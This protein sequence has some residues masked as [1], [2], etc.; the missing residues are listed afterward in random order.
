MPQP[1]DE[2]GTL[3]IES[4]TTAPAFKP[5]HVRRTK[6]IDD[7]RVTRSRMV[8][9]VAP[10][11]YGKTSLLAEWAER[12][13]RQTAWLTLKPGDD[14]P[15]EL[16]RMVARSCAGLDRGHSLA[17]E[18]IVASGGDALSRMAPAVGMA[19]SDT[20]QPF[21]LFID[22][23]HVLNDERSVDALGIALAGVPDGS[24][25]VLAGR[26]RT[27]A[28][29]RWR[30]AL[31]SAH[32]GI[33]QLRIDV[34][35]AAL[36][37]RE[38]GATT[39]ESVL[40]EWVS[41]CEGWAA[42]LHMCALLAEENPFAAVRDED[43]LADYLYQECMNGLPGEARDFLLRTSVLQT[44]IPDLCDAV[45]GRDDSA[46]ILRELEARQMFVTAD[47]AH[48]TYHLH[49]LF[50]EYLRN[51]L[52][53]DSPTAASA[54]HYKAAV[55]FQERGQLTEAIDHAIAANEFDLA[56]ALVTA[57][58]LGTYEAGQASR[59]GR[60]LDQIGDARVLANPAAVVV[61][62]W[63][64][65][66][67][68]SDKDAEKWSTLLGSLP[69]EAEA[70]GMNVASAKAM[71][72]A[73]SMKG[74]FDAALSDA[75][76]ACSIEGIDSPWRDPALQI[77]GSTLLHAGQTTRA[78]E[79]L[80]AA[81]HVADARNNAASLA[82]CE[83]DLS[84]LAIEAGEWTVAAERTATVL[85]AIQ[86]AGIEDYVMVPYA[87]SAAACAELADGR[88]S[89]GMGHLAWG[90]SE[91]QRCGSA[92]PLLG[93]PTR[94]LLARANLMVGDGNAVKVLLSEIDAM[95][96][97][98]EGRGVLDARIEFMREALQDFELRTG[99]RN[100][101][102]ALTAAEQR[103]LP[104]LQTHL[105]RAEIAQRLF[106]SPNTVGTQMSMIFR[107]FGAT[108]RAE[109][110][111]TAFELELLGG[112]PDLSHTS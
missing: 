43:L 48:H 28:Y 24:Q 27:P 55:W 41:R 4:R 69:D 30:L 62:T 105:T 87:C 44:H 2:L 100:R 90:M 73:I 101:S 22:D 21:V 85:R 59:L 16:I 97:P 68:G 14:D 23:T 26:H 56:I 88:R 13:D 65:V 74:G 50:Q 11:G 36:I 42:G 34:E 71:I 110:V 79:V 9:I 94:L 32:V 81:K 91:R 112:I 12:E 7:L 58:G 77:L 109:A 1:E 98:P 111:R 54:I 60:W 84:F 78:I 25:V 76:F 102:M 83:T 93:I 72:R 51:E 39:D 46:R 53:L 38:A 52:D 66:L 40:R 20:A 33:E 57:V 92:V 103:L 80:T 104:Y 64:S 61:I 6:L 45:R 82:I 49:P 29:A 17:F 106:L 15:S 107:K 5:E 89:E 75:D 86:D 70:A 18:Q 3:L 95:N 8:T 19:L 67:A 31:S 35:G 10:A 37:A 47:R 108:T 63:Y 99:I 96:P